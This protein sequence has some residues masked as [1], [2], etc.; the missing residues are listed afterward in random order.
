LHK[1]RYVLVALLLAVL[2]LT[3]LDAAYAA[4]GGTGVY[5][6]GYRVLLPGIM[7]KPGLCLRN[8]CYWYNADAGKVVIVDDINLDA[9]IKA[10]ADLVTIT[11]VPDFNILGAKY[12]IGVLQ[13]IGSAHLKSQIEATGEPLV[14]STAR[15]SGGGD[16]LFIPGMLGWQYGNFHCIGAVFLFFP[17]GQYKKNGEINIGKNRFAV[18]P[19]IAVTW[20]Q[21]EGGHEI[22]LA[23]GYTMN[24][25]NK[26]TNYKTGDE[27][28]FD[29]TLA[30]HFA[31]GL[32][33]GL[34]SYF[35]K[36]LA[37]RCHLLYNDYH[38]LTV[39]FLY[40]S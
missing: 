30:Q 35:Y 15:A 17:T 40:L 19:N 10:F 39:A 32:A 7:P 20:L 31:S 2:R 14:Q 29:F 9:E 24:S 36:Q 18:D 8:D 5:L 21:A 13:P 26:N 38:A 33:V 6:L 3:G 34:G 1:L 12:G 28:H 22:S 11:Y 4:E 27:L 25:E 23:A 16:T 37:R